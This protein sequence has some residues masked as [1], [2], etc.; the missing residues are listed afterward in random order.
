[1]EADA[2]LTDGRIV[3]RQCG[4]KDAEAICE[5]VRE[6]IA[7]LVPWMP[8]CSADY[9]MSTCRPWLDGRAEAWAAGIEYDFVIIDPR[10]GRMLGGCGLNQINRTHNFA[11][12]GY[13]VRTS[14]T[15]RGIG[16]AAARLVARFGFEQLGLT[17]LEIVVSVGNRASQRVAEK[18]GA[19]HEG[20]ARGRCVIH[21]RI[22]DAVM[23]SLA[24]KDLG[25]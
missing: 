4:P 16:T 8:W 24:P 11:N 15:G 3:I 1:M 18:A 9:D 23:Y 2:V 20:I 13:W 10:T 7:E 17:R 21:Q 19:M 12:L 22:D 5:A 6:S 25:L 14:E